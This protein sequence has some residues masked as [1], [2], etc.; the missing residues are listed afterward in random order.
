MK[1]SAV[2]I[3]LIIM[4]GL[5]VFSLFV[6]RGARARLAAYDRVDARGVQ[7]IGRVDG[8]RTSGSKTTTYLIDFEFDANGRTYQGSSPVTRDDYRSAVAGQP[9]TVIYL[10]ENPRVARAAQSIGRQKAQGSLRAAWM[11]LAL[12]FIYPTV[13][14]WLRKR[15]VRRKGDWIIRES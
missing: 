10:P 11:M 3:S 2:V 4:L 15:R 5:G 7:T 8:R 6:I 1:Q 9:I 14:F 13:E 12:A